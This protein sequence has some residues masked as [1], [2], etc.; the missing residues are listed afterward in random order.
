MQVIP[1]AIKQLFENE[2]H[3]VLRI[4]GTDPN[5]VAINITDA[6]VLEGSFSIDRYC[7]NG[8]KFEIGTAIAAEMKMKLDNRDG[9]FSNVVFEGT[10]L[11]VE[12]GIADWTQ[13]NPTITYIPCGYFTPDEQ[14]RRL[15]TISITALD[16][17]TK[18]DEVQP[19]LVE[20]VDESGNNIT[21]SDGNLLYFA[22]NLNTPA[23]VRNLI[24]QICDICGVT[25]AVEDA[26]A[27]TN[28]TFT[29]SAIPQL[30]QQVTFRNI[31][32]W[33]AGLLGSIAFIDWDGKL[34]FPNFTTNDSYT[35][36]RNN[37]FSGDMAEAD[38]TFTGVSYQTTDNTVVVSGDDAYTLDLSGNYL[39]PLGAAQLMPNIVHYVSGKTYRPFTARVI[40]APY[41]WPFDSVTYYDSNGAAHKSIV[42]NVNFGINCATAIES[43]G[44]TA[45]TNSQ[46]N[47][48]GV[49]T[50]QGKLIEQVAQSTEK[51]NES[52]NQEEIFNRLTNNGQVQGVIMNNGQLYINASYI[53]TGTLNADLIKAGKIQDQ[54]GKSYWNL[55]TGVMSLIGDLLTQYTSDNDTIAINIRNGAL[56][57][58]INGTTIGILQPSSGNYFSSGDTFRITGATGMNIALETQR[59]TAELENW[60]G[61]YLQS[62]GS[63]VLCCN[64]LQVVNTLDGIS[65]PPEYGYTGQITVGDQTLWVTHGIITD[66]S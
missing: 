54:A 10:E 55:M 50:I 9:T 17:M 63:A 42:T 49:T 57:F 58:E 22:T 65:Y 16:R 4:T 21:D 20:W 59:A 45:Q 62:D 48:S 13:D 24:E 46:A 34:H 53:N 51:L 29:I 15:D 5:G 2:H 56:Y 44:E 8:T 19:A 30:Q 12:I 3:Q 1:S 61:L 7:C 32:Q 27:N 60:A 37:R 6:N 52:L 41:V 43:K 14:P 39:I 36:N 18:F 66:V 31:I 11:F 33:C 35:C 23:T 40:A 64:S 47:P 25:L 26:I 28:A 38:I